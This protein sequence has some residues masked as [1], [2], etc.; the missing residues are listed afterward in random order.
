MISLKDYFYPKF[1]RHRKALSFLGEKH[2]VNWL[3][4]SEQE[5][6]IRYEWFEFEEAVR[7][8]FDA[9]FAVLDNYRNSRRRI[10]DEQEQEMN[11][12]LIISDI[13]GC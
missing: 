8:V 5:G 2:I 12:K 10:F 3:F 6:I 11:L 13:D 1:F 7:M 9:G 4:A